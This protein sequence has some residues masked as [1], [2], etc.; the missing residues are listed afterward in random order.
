MNQAPRASGGASSEEFFSGAYRRILKIALGLSVAAIVAASIIWNWRSGAA[1]GLGALV[2]Y[3]NVVWLHRGVEM[4]VERMSAA[5]TSAP[6]PAPVPSKARLF[7]AFVGR[8]VFVL[9][10]AYVIFRGYPQTRV[11]F[12]AGLA[13]PV[14]AAMCEGIYEAALISKTDKTP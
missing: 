13:L 6:A 1:L 9:A 4:A 14:L 5:G 8:Y 12:I 3:V 2:A 11:A 7:L 10:A